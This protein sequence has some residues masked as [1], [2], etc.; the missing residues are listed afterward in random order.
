MAGGRGGLALSFKRQY[1][2]RFLFEGEKIVY[3]LFVSS[4]NLWIVRA[5][6]DGHMPKIGTCRMKSKGKLISLLTTVRI[7]IEPQTSQ[8]PTPLLNIQ[9]AAL[10]IL[11]QI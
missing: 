4:K 2:F 3:F 5:K 7:P 11:H 9:K 6:Y 1:S 8:T 10:N